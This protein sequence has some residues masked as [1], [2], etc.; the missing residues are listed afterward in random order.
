MTISFYRNITT[1]KC[2]I[3]EIIKVACVER[4]GNVFFFL[5]ETV[6]DK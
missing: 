4:I 3:K 1:L 6:T 5:A 2:N